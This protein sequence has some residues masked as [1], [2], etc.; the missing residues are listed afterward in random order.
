MWGSEVLVAPVLQQGA[1]KRNVYLP[2]GT[3]I[4]WNDPSVDYSGQREI[5]YKAPLDVMPLFIRNGAFIPQADYDMENTGDYNPASYTI[6]YFPRGEVKSDYTLFED[7]RT[8]SGSL[9]AGEYALIKFSGSAT[10]GRIEIDVEVSGYYPGMPAERCLDFVLPA[11]PGKVAA[12]SVNGV[13]ADF[14]VSA[15]K[16]VKFSAKISSS[17]SLK[18]EVLME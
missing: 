7:D 2:A 15:K 13:N 16:D 14:T 8:S 9:A 1:V 3:W 12:V 11:L 18:I 10:K 6:L 4:D 17:N 5:S